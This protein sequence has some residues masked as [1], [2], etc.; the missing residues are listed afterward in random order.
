MRYDRYAIYWLPEPRSALAGFARDWLGGDPE[1]GEPWPARRRY[2]L[3]AE[4]VE[5]ATVS[6]RRYGCHATMKAPFC[7]RDGLSAADLSRSIADFCA[8]RRRVRAGR[9]R[10]HRLSRYLALTLESATAEV[11][12]LADECVT[13]FDAFR[14]PLHPTETDVRV[15]SRAWR[16]SS[17]SNSAMRIFSAASCSTSPLPDRWNRRTSRGSRRPWRPPRS[18][19]RGSRFRS[20][21]CACAATRDRAVFSR[22]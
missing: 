21:I 7:L 18:P 10:L 22:S 14:A 3:D 13:H 17:W 12:W 6:P 5:A 15:T 20:R 8:R 2:G 1:M 9:L 4:L 11:D 16:F 19:L